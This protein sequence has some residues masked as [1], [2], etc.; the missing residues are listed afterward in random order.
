MGAKLSSTRFQMDQ[1]SEQSWTFQVLEY[2]SWKERCDILSTSKVHHQITRADLFWRWLLSRLEIENGVYF[3][4]TRPTLN[5]K[6]LFKELYVLKNMWESTTV[7]DEENNNRVVN[8][9]QA[10]DKNKISVYARFSPKRLQLN[11]IVDEN[12]ENVNDN[13]DNDQ[14]V[15]LPLYQRLAM[16]KL[17]HN[18]KGNRQALKVLASEGGK[19]CSDISPLTMLINRLDLIENERAKNAIN[20]AMRIKTWELKL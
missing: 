4:K 9:L 20:N 3:P 5:Y 14:E 10:G 6:S 13:G 16:I 17:S 18:L 11:D 19:K 2:C 15:T 8:S 7:E 12:N 1:D